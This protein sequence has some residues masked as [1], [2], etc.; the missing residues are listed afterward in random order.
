MK[1]KRIADYGVQIGRMPR[2]KRNKITDVPGV[3]VGHCTV[4]HDTFRTGVTVIEPGPDNPFAHKKVAAAHVLNGYGKTLGL[5][6]VEELGTLETPIALTGTLNVGLVHDALVQTTLERC[7]AEGMFPTSINP[8]VGECHDG[9]LSDLARRPV[10]LE[11]VRRAF[12]AACEDF[13]EGAVGAG[14]GMV[15][16]GLKGGVG[17]ASRLISVGDETFTLGVLALTNHGSLADLRIDGE[18][19]GKSLLARLQPKEDDDKGSVIVLVAT[20]LPVTDRQ[21]RRILRRAPVGLAR[22]GSIIGH[23]S[24]DIMLGFSTAADIAHEGGEPVRTQRV[25]REDL[26]EHAFRAV[27]ECCEES[28]LNSLICARETVGWKG[29]RVRALADLWPFPGQES[30]TAQ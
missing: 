19:V 10:R 16:H 8:V 3:R 9:R 1:Q 12:E 4:D 2:G 13:E 27:A 5:V 28:V 26:L 6:Q 22:C 7:H 17:S 15:C 20:D 14:R 24:G 18:A 25:L 11:H 30:D 21:L 29:D 23:G